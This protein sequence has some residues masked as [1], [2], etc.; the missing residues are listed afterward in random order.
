MFRDAETRYTAEKLENVDTE[1]WKPRLDLIPAIHLFLQGALTS[2]I[3]W[4]QSGAAQIHSLKGTIT[5]NDAQQDTDGETKSYHQCYYLVLVERKMKSRIRMLRAEVSSLHSMKE[6]N[7]NLLTSHYISVLDFLLW[8]P[9]GFSTKCLIIY[10]IL[11]KSDSY[12]SVSECTNVS[13][14]SGTPV[15]SC[16]H[17][18]APLLLEVLHFFLV[19]A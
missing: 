9:A 2:P 5:R 17:L 10:F 14:F 3:P 12:S 6:K 13:N 16:E 18:T 8:V 11:H 4:R 19:F 1:I 7:V 15:A